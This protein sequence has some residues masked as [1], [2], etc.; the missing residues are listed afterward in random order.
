MLQ[1]WVT[2]IML[3]GGLSAHS[4]FAAPLA[5]TLETRF[6]NNVNQLRFSEPVRLDHAVI[7]T[8]QH[9]QLGMQDVDW[10]S[11]GLFDLSH[12]FLF[13]RDV[14]LKIVEMQSLAPE[15]QRVHWSSL[16]KQLRSSDFA[17]RIFTPV[18]PDWTRIAPQDNP[19]LHGQWLLNLI[20]KPNYVSV[21]GAVKKP[22]NIKWVNRQSAKDYA[23][24]AGLVD[25]QISEIVVIQPDGV[26]QKH[27]VAYWNMTFAE[28]AP[29]AIVYVPMPLHD[30]S[31]YPDTPS[32]DANQLVIEL[33]RNRLPL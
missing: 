20:K 31:F 26:V 25:E 11:S 10:V 23:Q 22:G 27:S 5:T 32:T 3:V 4:L 16:D 9:Y 12:A 13:K 8:L 19:R 17:K 30:S 7:Q 24:A 28:V 33:L 21:Y 6:A 15:S 18:D 29:G 2:L 1:R 14:L